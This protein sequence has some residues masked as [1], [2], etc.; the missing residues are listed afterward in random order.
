ML[1][2]KVN[3][4][5]YPELRGY[6]RSMGH[7]NA[8]QKTNFRRQSPQHVYETAYTFHKRNGSHSLRASQVHGTFTTSLFNYIIAFS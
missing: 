2:V 8:T 4:N 1:L 3:T 5:P 7:N 6:T